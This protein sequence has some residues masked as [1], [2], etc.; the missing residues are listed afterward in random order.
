CLRLLSVSVAVLCLSAPL[1]ILSACGGG[2]AAAPVTSLGPPASYTL[3]ATAL[4]PSSVIVGGTSTSTISVT[5]VNGY[6]GKVS[7]SCSSITGGTPPPTC[8]FSVSPIT[9]GGAAA[10]T[11]TLTV[12]T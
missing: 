1:L 2:A 11:S 7:L 8:S 12:S 6:S 10:G 4:T 3:A 9:V 5:P